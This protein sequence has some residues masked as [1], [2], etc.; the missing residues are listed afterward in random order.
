[1]SPTPAAEV[2]GVAAAVAFLTRIPV[3]RLL[4]LDTADVAR[5]G[6]FFPLV[7]LGI[8]ALVG[9]IAQAAGNSLTAPLAAVLGVAV[10]AALTGALHLDGLAD[11][12]DALT[13]PTRERAL[14]IMRDHAIGTYGAV[15]LVLDLGAKVVALSALVTDHD[16]LRAAVC[17]CAAARAVPVVLSVVLPYARPTAGLGRALGATG[18]PRAAFAVVTAVLV[19]VLLHAALLLAVVGGAGIVCG[20][21]ARRWLGGVTGDVLGAAAELAETGALVAAV[22]LL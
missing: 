13:A 17:A 11:T 20:L 10:G 12:A 5:G 22:A 21:A 7:G 15:A 19:C 1:M 4:E 8:G 16:A 9:G 2:R 18:W 6:A 3:G 14:E